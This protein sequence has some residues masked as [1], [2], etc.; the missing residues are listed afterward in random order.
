MLTKINRVMWGREERP[1]TVFVPWDCGHHCPFCTTKAEYLTKYP[2]EKLGYYFARLKES[3]RRL[4][5]YGFVDDVVFTGGEPLARI[6]WLK[7][8]I[9]IARAGCRNVYVN[10]TLNL[11]ERQS[12][13]AFNFL[14]SA[15]R[16]NLI[17]GISV[18]LPYVDVSMMNARGYDFLARFIRECGLRPFNWIRVNSVLKGDE[19]PDQI[20]RF[21][22]DID[23][24][25]CGGLPGAWAIN[26]RKNYTECTQ[27]NL[28]DWEDPTLQTLMGMEDLHYKGHAGCFVC[29]NDVFWPDDDPLRRLVYHRGTERTSLRCGD[30]MIINDIVIKQDGEI[31]YDWQEGTM[32][33]KR[34][35]DALSGKNVHPEEVE[36]KW[37]NP[38]FSSTLRAWNYTNTMTCRDMLPERCG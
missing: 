26:L 20:R 27:A 13:E 10:T 3:L 33:P 37:K 22:A 23:R 35:M 16:V 8:L 30:L 29:R 4:M 7:E 25:K 9:E 32:L 12:E 6:D 21:V 24:L 15:A 1:A 18:S 31:R 28:N 34:V 38:V 36:W 5:E 11:D 14:L 2:R 17:S 19:T